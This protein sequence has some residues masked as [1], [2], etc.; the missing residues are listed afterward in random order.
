LAIRSAVRFFPVLLALAV[1]PVAA[2]TYRQLTRVEDGWINSGF[3]KPAWSSSGSRVVCTYSWQGSMHDQDG[4]AIVFVNVGDG[5]SVRFARQCPYLLP[6]GEA[7]WSPAEDKI[8]YICD[9]DLLIG[10]VPKSVQK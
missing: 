5:S 9:G 7:T 10:L 1:E 2:V 8:A 6:F 3:T 4:R